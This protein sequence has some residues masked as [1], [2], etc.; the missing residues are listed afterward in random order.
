MTT[1]GTFAE[2][3]LPSD[4]RRARGHL[5]AATTALL[6][7]A[8]GG[9]DDAPVPVAPQDACAALTSAQ[10]TEFSTTGIKA[11]Y[12]AASAS[13]PFS[14]PTTTTTVTTPFCRVEAT[15][16]S[17]SNSNIGFE[18]WLPVREQWNSKFAGTASGGSAGSI[19]YGVVA[20][21]FKAGYASIGHDNGHV[22]TGFTQTWAYDPATKSL[23]N[24]QIIDWSY[25][26]QH[27]VTVVAKQL[28]T[29]FYASPIQHSYYDGCSQS[30]HHG[31]M[32]A[33]RYP[34]DY[35]GIVAG[36][37]TSE[38]TTNMA[39]Q[40]W[41]AFQQYGNGG[42]GAITRAQ[43]TAVHAGVL[44][45]CD[46]KPGVDHLADGSLDDPRLCN[47]DPVVLQCTGGAGDPATC[48]KPA[49]VQSLRA[50]YV[51][52]KT[53]SGDVTA[54]PY[55]VGA[56]TGSFWPTNTTTPANPQGSWADYFRYPVFVNP[57]YDLTTL[58]FD[59]DPYIARAKLRPTYDAYSTDLSAFQ[60]RGGKLLM[61]HGWADSLIS[62]YLSIDYW[63][64]LRQ[65]MSA[66]EVDKF[67]RMY[68][69]PGVDH[70]GGGAG[71]G[72][73]SLLDALSGW[74]EKGVAPDGTN[75]L[76]TVV[77]TATDG[78]TRPLCPYPQIA[79]YTG[80]GDVKLAASFTCQAP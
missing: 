42:V 61:Y 79:R 4:R 11:T 21:H 63:I 49:Q 55:P 18:L 25:R 70:C 40:A 5:I 29:A 39:S 15:A 59:V 7:G 38:W 47:F 66:T 77:A 44:A 73:F 2:A 20:S 1:R 35:D 28:T 78:H 9:G 33:Q 13:A 62:P 60:K 54:Y 80:T 32:E 51:G 64:A 31:M 46:G 16:H 41:V 36:A 17:N 22:S 75:A 14:V 71:T 76:N 56:E 58:N 8:C 23:K 27:V 74:V 26:A 34:D 50:M 10:T 12:V 69:V 57:A 52:H 65:T 43:Y 45:A 6:L 48:L 53:P 3:L 37:H 72:N 24:D 30:G 19:S 67:A 68:L